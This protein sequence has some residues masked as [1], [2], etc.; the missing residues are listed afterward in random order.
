MNYHI[1]IYKIR[2][3]GV[4]LSKKQKQTIILY[5]TYDKMNKIELSYKQM[6]L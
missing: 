6:E 3:E 5:W 2:N 4:I 1:N